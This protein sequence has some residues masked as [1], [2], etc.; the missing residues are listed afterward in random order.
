LKDKFHCIGWLE[1]IS[2]RTAGGVEI[3]SALELCL[4]IASE[5]SQGLCAE[6]TFYRSA[7]HATD[8]SMHIHW[9][10]DT[11]GPLKSNFGV[12]VARMLSDFGIINHTLWLPQRQNID[13][14]LLSR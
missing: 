4:Q 14:V 13:E 6:L 10:A 2:V 3:E 1:I 11:E 7:L 9:P 8:L 12:Q 5:R